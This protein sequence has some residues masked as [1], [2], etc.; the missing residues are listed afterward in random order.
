MSI[1]D[2]IVLRGR[3]GSNVTL[4]VPDEGEDKRPFARFRMAVPQARRRDDGSWEEG[5]AQWYTV[6]AWGSLAD[7][8]YASVHKGI[9]L[10]VVGRP[11]AQAWL[12]EDGELRSEVAVNARTIGPDLTFG[13]TIFRRYVTSKR[14]DAPEQAGAPDGPEGANMNE[15]L[16]DHGSPSQPGTP[17][18][19]QAQ[20]EEVEAA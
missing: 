3:A 12:T 4:Y 6:R 16:A 20:E 1:H 7:N 17:V 13:A 8:A 19:G 14:V 5:E 2:L 15:D 9:P 18:G 11:T 10:V